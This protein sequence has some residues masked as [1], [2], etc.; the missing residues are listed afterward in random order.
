MPGRTIPQVQST[1][2]C[3]QD[4]AL[5]RSRPTCRQKIGADPPVQSGGAVRWHHG[6]MDRLNMSRARHHASRRT[7]R[8]RVW[9]VA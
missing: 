1:V 5:A 9:A 7:C 2:T 6:G 3:L 8:R 4:S